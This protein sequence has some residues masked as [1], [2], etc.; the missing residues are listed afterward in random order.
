MVMLWCFRIGMAIAGLVVGT[1]CLSVIKTS[2]LRRKRNK[3]PS[4]VSGL[5]WLGILAGGWL[6]VHKLLPA[7]EL[8]YLIGYGIALVAGFF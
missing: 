6:C 8:P 4:F 3:F 2:L 5:L 1:L 7:Y